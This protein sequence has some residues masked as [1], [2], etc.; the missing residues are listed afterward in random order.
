MNNRKKIKI[1]LVGNPNCGKT[2]VFNLLTGLHQ[3][4]GNFP[5][6]TVDRKIGNFNINDNY[7]IQL[8]D[9]PGT[10][11]LYPLSKDERIVI[12]SLLQKSDENY[13]ELIIYVVDSTHLEKN[14]LLFTQIR[15]LGIPIVMALN[16]TDIANAN[17][18]EINAVK[19]S[20]K[21]H[22]PV[23]KISGRTGEGLLDLKESI[24]TLYEK[25]SIS[26]IETCNCFYTLGENEKT[27]AKEF[28]NIFPDYN[29]YQS[30]VIAHHYD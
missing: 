7:S 29:E 25:L 3:K 18:L 4:T 8:I 11:S 12:Q 10:Y 9:L 22:T 19:L 27:I 20:K 6:I 28:Q 13:P 16:M 17:G 2:S 1:A 14:L 30:L 5:G 26:K 15:D 24:K 21:L 23:V